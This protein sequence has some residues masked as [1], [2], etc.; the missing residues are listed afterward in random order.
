MLESKDVYD[1]LTEM[2]ISFYSGVPDSLLKDFCA[3]IT[4]NAGDKN[5]IIAANE[6]NAVGLA[7]GHYLATG[8]PAVVFMQN[9]GLGNAINPLTSLVDTD[10]YSIPILLIIGWRGE[11]GIKDE[12][13]HVKQG[14]ITIPL[15]ETLGI[16]FCVL[17]V[18]VEE[19]REVVRLYQATISQI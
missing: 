4:D 1:L 3:Y 8:N 6:G 10:V 19:G 11:P 2:K 18:T 9:S 14:K 16:D 5:H 12:P 17:P 7:A 13:Q 15:L